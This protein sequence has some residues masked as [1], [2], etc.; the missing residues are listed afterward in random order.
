MAGG[1]KLKDAAPARWHDLLEGLACDSLLVTHLANVRYLTGF[2]GS[3]GCALITPRQR[4]FFTDF[5]YRTQAAREVRGFRMVITGGPALTG[6]ADHVRR[7]RLKLGVL[8]YEAGHLTQAH[9][10]A[11]KKALK[12]VRLKDCGGAVE[13]L[14]QVKDS[15]EL[16]AVRRACRIADGALAQLMRRRLTGRSE[17]EVSWMLEQAMR[18]AGSGPLPFP[19]IVA[20]GP[21]SAMPHAAPTRR[22]IRHGE[23]VVIDMGA[24]V[25]GYC[26]DITR[27][28]A[29]GKLPWRL[30]QVYEVVRQA[31][32]LALAAVRPGAACAAVDALA[33]GRISEAGY[34]RQFG[35]ALGHGVGLE[36]HEG[37]VLASRSRQR[38]ATGMTVTVEPGIYLEGR[39]GVRIEDTVLVGARGPRPLTVTTRELTYLR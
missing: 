27:T 37:P 25:G 17:L 34:G 23:L 10:A 21:R 36:A 31:Q 3:A 2:T 20:S 30:A 22:A 29:T 13:R 1:A 4:L 9:F 33:R 32:E 15:T 24:S 6:A 19:V 12:G 28:F 39:G 5:R 35:H 16:A 11:L 7:R 8:G 18:E 38:L 14:R 26:S